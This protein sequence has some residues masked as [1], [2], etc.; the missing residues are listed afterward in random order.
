MMA[1]S[2][3]FILL[4]VGGP[5]PRPSNSWTGLAWQTIK[6]VILTLFVPH[7]FRVHTSYVSVE[8]K[9][10]KL[11]QASHNE[12]SPSEQLFMSTAPSSGAAPSH[13]PSYASKVAGN[14]KTQ[15]T[16]QIPRSALAVTSADGDSQGQQKGGKAAGGRE[17]RRAR[18]VITV[19]RTEGY[20]QWLEENPLQA[21]IAGD[22]DEDLA[23]PPPDIDL[24]SSMPI[25]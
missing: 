3:Y 7:P 4:T 16:V 1:S 18:I 12:S 2:K 6:I 21:I 15:T 10:K 23:A 11:P 8:P 17:L 14:T 20:K 9:R 22:G 5:L 13:A 19:K 25:T 24:L